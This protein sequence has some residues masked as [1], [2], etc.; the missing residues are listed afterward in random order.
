MEKVVILSDTH[1]NLKD[2]EKLTPILQEADRILFAG[3]G[4]N[5]FNIFPPEI[6]KKIK[7]VSGNCDFSRFPKELVFNIENKRVLLCH[8]DRYGVKSGLIRLYLRA[9]ELKCDVAVYG[10]T[11]EK[12]I[13]EKDG[14]LFVNPGTLSK[15][16][17]C[18]TFAYTV[19]SENKIIAAI[20]ENFFIT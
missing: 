17:P 1:G 10:H 7:I 12:S 16:A 4:A 13:E 9:K 18:K 5:D 3:D 11:H 14:I 20:N 19:F 15:F 8:G 2:L 6:Y